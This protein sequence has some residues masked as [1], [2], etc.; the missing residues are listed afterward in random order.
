VALQGNTGRT[1]EEL[2]RIDTQ[3]ELERQVRREEISKPTYNPLVRTPV[4]LKP[5]T[6]PEIDNYAEALLRKFMQGAESTV[7]GHLDA[8][9]ANIA[10]DYLTGDYKKRFVPGVRT[11]LRMNVED[12]ELV[13]K[14][15]EQA[16]AEGYDSL[17]EW[18]VAKANEYMSKNDDYY[19]RKAL[20]DTDIANQEYG[21]L[22]NV[23]LEISEILGSMVPS[24]ALGNVSGAL[25]KTLGL[26]GKMAWA[27]QGIITGGEIADRVSGTEA[28]YIYD[29][30]AE[31]KRK[32]R[33]E[34]VT[35]EDYRDMIGKAKTVG[36]LIGIAEAGTEMLFGGLT[37]LG[38]GLLDD[39]V[40][41]VGWKLINEPTK[42]AINAWRNTTSGHIIS[43]VVNRMN[44]AIGEGMEEAIM[45]IAQPVIE[46]QVAGIESEVTLSDIARDFGLGAAV[47]LV[48]GIPV[49][50]V[51]AIDTRSRFQPT[52]HLSMH[53]P[54]AL[55]FS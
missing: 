14:A 6:S 18:E 3:R 19:H 1:R 49:T 33:S 24:M 11:G 46:K 39:T 48:V 37:F 41:K 29:R 50:A 4:E 22:G 16:K 20:L 38:K 51:D 44:G 15:E 21:S 10:E 32:T 17:E 55:A 34:D 23:G 13:K 25:V 40:A 26:T 47:S 52:R 45:A 27:L 53:S 43:E 36:E 7:V 5:D 28:K 54:I 30:L 12:P 31:E 35:I 2:E 42:E 8:N 9:N